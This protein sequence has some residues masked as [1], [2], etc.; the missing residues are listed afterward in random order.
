[1]QQ[2]SL[3]KYVRSFSKYEGM[4]KKVFICFVLVFVLFHVI[5]YKVQYDR[6][7]HL[8]QQLAQKVLRFH[9]LANSNSVEDQTLKLQI[10]DAIGGYM[11][12]MLAGGVDKEESKQRIETHLSE[13]EEIAEEMLANEGYDYKVSAS[14]TECEF[15]VKTYG[16][17]TFPAGTYEALRVVIGEGAGENWWCVLYPNMC[18]ENS[19]YEV[20]DEKA[21]N[22]LRE[23][24]NQE[25]Y[26]AVLNSGKYEIRFR[27]LEW[28]R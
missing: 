7:I 26:Q 16:D 15:P 18:F 4:V 24:L 19:I 23:V 17:Y 10:R 28:F 3:S 20:V 14:V 5:I 6:Q 9:V 22:A 27:F 11:Q 25:E 1:M 12:E 13:I 2:N 21:K 8:Q